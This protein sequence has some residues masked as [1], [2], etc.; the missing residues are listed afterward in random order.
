MRFFLFYFKLALAC[1]PLAFIGGLLAPWMPALSVGMILLL[2]LFTIGFG[3][4]VVFLD[5]EGVALVSVLGLALL[6]AK[7]VFVVLCCASVGWLMSFDHGEKLYEVFTIP[8]TLLA[9]KVLFRAQL[10]TLFAE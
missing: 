2:S 4:V 10:S 3:I 7:L 6:A 1:T 5:G 8:L 9:L